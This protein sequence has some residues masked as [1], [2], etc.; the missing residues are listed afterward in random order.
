MHQFEK[1]FNAFFSISVAC[2]A[3]VTIEFMVE[4][5]KDCTSIRILQIGLKYGPITVSVIPFI[6]R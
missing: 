5:R 3:F 1:T 2:L 4:K 6:Y